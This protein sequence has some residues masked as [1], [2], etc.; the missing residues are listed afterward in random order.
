M[1]RDLDCDSYVP[2]TGVLAKSCAKYGYNGYCKSTN[3]TSWCSCG[4]DTSHCDFYP[5]ERRSKMNTVDMIQQARVDGKMYQYDENTFYTSVTG[6]IDAAGEPRKCSDVTNVAINDFL[7][8]QWSIVE[9][10][11]RQEAEERLGV[12]IVG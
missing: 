7:G 2:V 10:M 5:E 3:C 6:F 9:T 11:T 1:K 4:G 8:L 12:K